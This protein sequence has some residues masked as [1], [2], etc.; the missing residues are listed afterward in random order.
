[1]GSYLKDEMGALHE[2]VIVQI[3]AWRAVKHVWQQ[4]IHRHLLHCCT[5]LSGW[6]NDV[7]KLLT[8]SPGLKP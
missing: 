6:A 7:L 8:T 2:G 5:L 3:S 1:M 4:L